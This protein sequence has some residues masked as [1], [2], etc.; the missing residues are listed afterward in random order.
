MPQPPA[1]GRPAASWP[2]C[3][4]VQRKNGSGMHV[5]RTITRDRQR[6]APENAENKVPVAEAL[7]RSVSAASSKRSSISLGVMAARR[8]SFEFSRSEGVAAWLRW[9]GHIAGVRRSAGDGLGRTNLSYSIQPA[10]HSAGL[11]DSPA[12]S[13]ASCRRGGLGPREPPSTRLTDRL[14]EVAHPPG[15]GAGAQ[16]ATD[17]RDGITKQT[18]RRFF[19]GLQ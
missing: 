15:S 12:A 17:L 16:G 19:S 9:R 18:R 8:S 1:I 6:G 7:Q 3:A 10:S 11:Q 4:D 14:R 2:G 5:A 13:S